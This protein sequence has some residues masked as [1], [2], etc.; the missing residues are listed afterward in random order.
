MKT[1]FEDR[2]KVKIKERK[3]NS[4][5]N[6]DAPQYDE[7]SSCFVTAGTDYGEGHKQPVGTHKHESSNVIPKGRV[8]TLSQYPTSTS[9]EFQ[10]DNG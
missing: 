2:I 3:A 4:P 1:G 7:R 8:N 6:F 5:W 10:E 9:R